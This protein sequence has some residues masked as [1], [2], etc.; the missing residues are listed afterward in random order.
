MNEELYKLL[1]LQ[2]ETGHCEQVYNF[3]LE[4]GLKEGWEMLKDE[5][6]NL[7]ATKGEGPYPCVVA[8]M[9]TVHCITV[10]G[11]RPVEIDGNVIGFNPVA[12]EQTGIGG[13]DKCGIW[14]ALHCLR[15]L[16]ACKAVFF[17]DEESGCHGSGACW[18]G[19]FEGC[20]FV[21]QADRR[22][23]DDFVNDIMGGISSDEFQY[24][25]EPIIRE[26]GYEFSDG[27]MSDVMQL[28]DDRVGISCANISA[29]YY[30][31]HWDEE[32]INLADLQNVCDLMMAICTRLTTAYPFI[33][34][35]PLYASKFSSPAKKEAFPD[36]RTRFYGQPYGEVE[37]IGEGMFLCSVCEDITDL[38]F[39]AKDKP[40][41]CIDCQLLIQEGRESTLSGWL[42]SKTKGRRGKRGKNGS[43]KNGGAK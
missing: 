12:M 8:H 42:R 30:N 1:S 7:Y 31:P 22:G 10:G 39:M 28:R 19:F 13:D 4:L 33:Y 2:S 37:I 24:D 38:H 17:V 26:F 15:T 6:G 29:G 3:L 41:T 11:I 16:P 25:V 14:A 34:E 36:W 23:N 35:P 43:S 20:R 21:L 18:L 5:K 40:P 9:D 27:A 32:F